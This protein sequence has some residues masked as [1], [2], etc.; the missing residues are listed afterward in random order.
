[1][2]AGP[3]FV[4]VLGVGNLRVVKQ[5]LARYEA[6][7]VAHIENI[8]SRERRGRWHRRF[9]Q[10]EEIVVSE[11]ERIE[12]SKRDLESTERFELQSETQKTIR[13]ELKFE[14]GLEVSGGFGPVQISAFANF[15]LSSS[16]E[17][18]S[19]NAT[20][21]AKDVIDRSVSRLM[22]RVRTYRAT[23]SVEETE[24]R[25][26][27]GF[28]NNSDEHVVGVYRWVDKYYRAKVVNY[29]KRLFFEFMV[30]EPATFYRFAVEAAQRLGSLPV[31]PVEPQRPSPN[32]PFA[33]TG[34]PLSPGD[35]TRTNYMTLVQLHGAQGVEPPPPDIIFVDRHM[36]REFNPPGRGWSFAEHINLPAGYSATIGYVLPATIPTTSPD[37]AIGL[38]MGGS[39]TTSPVM[40]MHGQQEAIG[41]SGMGLG[42]AELK[43]GIQ[44]ECNLAP[45]VFAKWQLKMYAA[46]MAAHNKALLDYEERLAAAQIQSG[47]AIAGRNPVVNREV[48]REELKRACL[49]LWADAD[50]D[51]PDGITAPV[52]NDP[53]SFPEIRRAAAINSANTIKFFESCFDWENMSY[54]FYP[55][56]WGRRNTWTASFA[57][58]DPDPL[59]AAFQ[60]AGYA[61][62]VVPVDPIYNAAVIYY[63]LGGPIGV[64]NI[65]DL[66]TATDPD[67]ILANSYLTDL[68]DATG[69][70]PPQGE[71]EIRADDPDTWLVKVPTDLV[72]LQND[73][74]LLP[75]F[76]A[77]GAGGGG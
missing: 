38:S 57:I 27:H 33:P 73:R 61:R 58:D 15:G 2:A 4:R 5:R 23:K 31:K 30:P 25:N 29:G 32:F 74:W 37:I 63:Q 52:P 16:E 13:S 55:Y 9:R 69:I 51:V 67:S 18:E 41:F 75:D 43:I 68:A 3:P 40:L 54:T 50:V 53:T 24:E 49:W 56:Y 70:E 19:L 8:M 64:S 10:V 42:W 36:A 62:V 45:E 65:P 6:G 71:S 21:Y 77:A 60:R 72:W 76:E 28:E 11:Q 48:E 14:A 17:E 59:F 66:S 12:E 44:I 34:Q 26:R 47:V 7:E 1:M 20:K 46:I 35:I 22:D 39:A